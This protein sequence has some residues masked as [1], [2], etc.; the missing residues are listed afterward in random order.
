[1]RASRPTYRDQNQN[2]H[3]SFK[4]VSSQHPRANGFKRPSPLDH[5]PAPKGVKTKTKASAKNERKNESL[6]TGLA[7]CL[8]GLGASMY[9]S[10][11]EEEVRKQAVMSVSRTSCRF[12]CPNLE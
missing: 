3:Q 7:I 11:Y 9:D 2:Q 8:F 4:T 10:E 1:M 5:R 12:Q 6:D